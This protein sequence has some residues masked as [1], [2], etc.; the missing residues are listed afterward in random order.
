MSASERPS[1]AALWRAGWRLAARYVPYALRGLR[2]R[3]AIVIGFAIALFVGAA[4]V[5]FDMLLLGGLNVVSVG[6]AAVAAGGGAL[7]AVSLTIGSASML[8]SETQPLPRTTSPVDRARNRALR[9]NP[10]TASQ[11][12]DATLMRVTDALRAHRATLSAGVAGNGVFIGLWIV[13]VTTNVS[14]IGEISA[15]GWVLTATVLVFVGVQVF[16]VR[17][18]GLT[19]W[20]LSVIEPVARQRFG[21]P[22]RVTN[23]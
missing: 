11:A 8:E 3:L 21:H 6:W 10:L 23:V 5:G 2:R 9:R 12:D 17:M 1:E 18:L 16:S 19:D 20:R 7:A 22:S 13:L 15:V 14:P 4:S